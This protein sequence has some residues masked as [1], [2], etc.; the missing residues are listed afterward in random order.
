MDFQLT[1]MQVVNL[2]FTEQKEGDSESDSRLRIDAVMEASDS[3]P[4]FARMLVTASL[5]SPGRYDL[6][7]DLAFIFKFEEKISREEIKNKLVD[8]DTERMLYPYINT[9]LTNFII[10]AGYPR[11][12]I[13]LVLK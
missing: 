7:V 1:K 2:N 4:R 5:Q 9:F 11:P 8:A 3:N 10:N 6:N 13:P 12:G